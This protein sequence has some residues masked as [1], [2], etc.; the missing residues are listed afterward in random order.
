[1]KHEDGNLIPRYKARLAVKSF[2]QIKGIDFDEIFSPI[3]KTSSICVV[4][5]FTESIGLEVEQM[6]VK[7]DFLHGDLD[8]EIYMEQPERFEA[9]GKENYVCKLKKSVY[10]SK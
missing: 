8:K 6:D 5:G 10:D 4:L 1:M 3:V 2:S 9:K 7:I